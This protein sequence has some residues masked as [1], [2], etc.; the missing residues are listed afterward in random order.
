MKEFS[1]SWDEGKGRVKER[2]PP[3]PPTPTPEEWRLWG[4]SRLWQGVRTLLLDTCLSK[5]R[6]LVLR[7][8]HRTRGT[9]EREGPH[10]SR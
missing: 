8:D 1:A 7:S 4:G 10:V 9:E 5:G 3:N 2:Q 6:T